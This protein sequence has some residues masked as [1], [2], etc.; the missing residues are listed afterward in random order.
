MATSLK[1]SWPHWSLI[2]SVFQLLLMQKGLISSHN[3]QVQYE[4]TF[5]CK[6]LVLHKSKISVHKVTMRR[7]DMQK[8]EPGRQTGRYSK[9]SEH[10]KWTAA[11]TKSLSPTKMYFR[12]VKNLSS[13]S[14]LHQ[15]TWCQPIVF[16]NL[17]HF[18]LWL[19][20]LEYFLVTHCVM[21]SSPTSTKKLDVCNITF[22][23]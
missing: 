2:Q 12:V 22:L 13:T 3:P 21:L 15:I 16:V 7:P 10:S 20:T 8:L 14:E 9:G 1:K 17:G 23:Q 6:N 5:Y 19:S 18:L 11:Y 4:Q